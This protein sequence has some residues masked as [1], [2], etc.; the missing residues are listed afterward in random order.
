MPERPHPPAWEQRFRSPALAL[1]MWAR[2]APER[3][4][5]ATNESGSWQIHAWDRAAG[6]RR[7][8]TD[9]PIGILSGDE[10]T[11]HLPTPDG[12]RIVWFDDPTGDETARWM[13]QPFGASPNG[14]TTAEPFLSGVP[15][16]WTTGIAIGDSIVA[17]G[18]GL[19]EGFDVYVS[20]DGGPARSVHHHAEIVAVADLS[21][22]DSMLASTGTASTSHSESF[23]PPRGRRWPTCG[24]GRD[25][26]C[27]PPCG[28]RWQAISVWRS[29]TNAVAGIDRASGIW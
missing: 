16:A 5:V 23:A 9:N 1:P 12:E 22:D 15:D 27:A 7:R 25:W 13:V 6:T 24:T 28:H 10:Q 26:G 20:V 11:T 3:L 8:V 19:P 17:V 29:C 14:R 21:P 2:R 18:T 4:T